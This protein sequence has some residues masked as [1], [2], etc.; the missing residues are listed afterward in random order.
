MPVCQ[1]ALTLPQPLGLGQLRHLVTLSCLCDIGGN[2]STIESPC[3]HGENMQTS[4]G[5]ERNVFPSLNK[6]LSNFICSQHCA[7]CWRYIMRW[8]SRHNPYP[9]RPHCLAWGIGF[10]HVSYTCVKDYEGSVE[11]GGHDSNEKEP[12]A[13]SSG[14]NKNP[15][16]PYN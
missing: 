16:S 5:G 1:Q 4:C 7:Q 11:E 15:C 8:G 6:H 14:L 13:W 10:N 3:R 12:T 2:L 9:C